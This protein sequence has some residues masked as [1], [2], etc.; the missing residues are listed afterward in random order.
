MAR[1]GA[2]PKT[3]SLDLSDD[4]TEA[5]F[6][7][8]S[9]PQHPKPSN[10]SVPEPARQQS[11]ELED[12][13]FDDIEAR[14]VVLRKELAGI[15]NMNH[16]IEGAIEGLERAGVNMDT[17]SS[18]VNDAS[19]LLNTWT[20]ILSQTEYNQRLIL[21]PSWRGATQD[22]ADIES[23]SIAKEQEKER[24]ELEE[25]QK[26]EAR[27][28]KA[29]ED[30]RRKAEKLAMKTSIT[31]RGR[32]HEMSRGGPSGRTTSYGASVAPAKDSGSRA[33]RAGSGIGR[34][35]NGYRGRSRGT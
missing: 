13:G 10:S 28:R 16:V 15:R 17:V 7:S 21:D 6:A 32:G 22:V 35:P 19:A 18:T 29:E 24:R 30:E 12:H 5:L 4:D 33:G 8:P 34:G 1:N 11:R 31:G 27:A 9:R 26:R 25:A 23:E 3:E 20:R 14:Q 2:T